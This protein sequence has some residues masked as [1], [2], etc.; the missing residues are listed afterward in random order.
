MVTV[1][2]IVMAV[3]PAKEH[4]NHRLAIYLTVKPRCH[5]IKESFVSNH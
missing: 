1:M 4:S 5:I 3:V 2:E